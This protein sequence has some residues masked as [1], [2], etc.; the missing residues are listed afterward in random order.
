VEGRNDTADAGEFGLA[1]YARISGVVS[2]AA[3]FPEHDVFVQVVG[4]ERL[5]KVGDDGSFAVE[6][7]PEGDFTLRFIAAETTAGPIGQMTLAAM[8]DVSVVVHMPDGWRYAR[9]ILLNTSASGADIDGDITGFPLLIRLSED[10]F[11]FEQAE[12][13]GS[14]IRFIKSVSDFLPCEIERWDTD[15]RQAELWVRVDTVFGGE[16]T[17]GLTMCWGNADA[18][19]APASWEPVFDTVD[20]FAGVWHL[21]DNGGTIRNAATDASDGENSGSTLV[22][23]LIGSSREFNSGDYIRIPGL[24]GSPSSVTLSAWVQPDTSAGGKDA[25]SIGDA[26][27]IRCDDIREIGTAG[28]YHNDTIVNESTY[29]VVGSG[30]YLSGTGWH[31]IT[32][33]IDGEAHLQTLYIDGVQSAVF[34]DVKAIN[35]NGLASDTY[36]GVH[37]NG[38]TIFNFIGLIDE[39]RIHTAAVSADWVRLCFM[40]QKASD[41]LLVW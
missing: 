12:K 2:A 3:S 37:G 7:L 33:T 4:L 19:A 27:L 11:N 13:D 22:S 35:Y 6:D 40:N 38:K 29:A 18:S 15:G 25:V 20:G 9:R 23:G 1:P 26:V 39:V 34:E 21:S 36:I 24:F 28:C 32:F 41:K 16:N 31:H 14:D 17:Q 10:N 30:Q 5:V 8:P